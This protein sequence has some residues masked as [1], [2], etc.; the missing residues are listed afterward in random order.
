MR[1]TSLRPPRRPRRAMTTTYFAKIRQK[2]GS[3]AKSRTAHNVTHVGLSLSHDNEGAAA[4]AYRKFHQLLLRSVITLAQRRR[5]ELRGEASSSSP[6]GCRSQPRRRVKVRSEVSKQVNKG[7]GVTKEE[8][9]VIMMTLMT[10]LLNADNDA[11]PRKIWVPSVI[12]K[13]FKRTQ[14]MAPLVRIASR[15]PCRRR[16]I[17][18]ES[19]PES[20]ARRRSRRRSR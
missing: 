18:S 13:S 8:I 6:R 19:G 15:V 1:P 10:L 4:A 3:Q 7:V 12:V 5:E 16:A 20:R 11:T 14:E 17:K 2:R 9:S